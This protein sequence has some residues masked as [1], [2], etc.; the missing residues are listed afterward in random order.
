[1]HTSGSHNA[2]NPSSAAVAGK[3]MSDPG[4][5][6]TANAT[7]TAVEVAAMTAALRQ[8]ADR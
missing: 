7:R 1:M 5:G 2:Q 8:N 3:P 4:T 6:P